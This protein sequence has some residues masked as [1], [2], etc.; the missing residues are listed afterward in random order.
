MRRNHQFN[1]IVFF[2]LLLTIAFINTSV[3]KDDEAGLSFPLQSIESISHNHQP[4]LTPNSRSEITCFIKSFQ[5]L[6]LNPV[7]AKLAGTVWE[8]LAIK[9]ILFILFLIQLITPFFIF[10]QISRTS[11]ENDSSQANNVSIL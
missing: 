7:F 5:S 4:I 9:I 2:V 11:S 3:I 1:W 6:T 10:Y 8:S